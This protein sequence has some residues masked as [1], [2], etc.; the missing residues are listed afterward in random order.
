LDGASKA[1]GLISFATLVCC[2][3]VI[4]EPQMR[5][6]YSWFFWINPTAQAYDALVSNEFHG[7]II[8]RVGASLM[9]TGPGYSDAQEQVCIG[10]A[11]APR[12]GIFLSGD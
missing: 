12:S 8:E 4:A 6:W 11:G 5:S 10:V 2:G 1:A 9:P 7:T 3:Y